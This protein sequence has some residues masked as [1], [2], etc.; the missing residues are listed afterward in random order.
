VEIFLE[1]NSVHE[2][3]SNVISLESESVKTRELI[4]PYSKKKD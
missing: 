1:E 2:V 3:I 4:I